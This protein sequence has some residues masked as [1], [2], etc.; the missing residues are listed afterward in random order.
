MGDISGLSS[1]EFTERDKEIMCRLQKLV[2]AACAVAG[3]AVATP[4]IAAP[5]S[6][7]S[8]EGVNW[9]SNSLQACGAP[10]CSG[11]AVEITPHTA[12]QPNNPDGSGAVWISYA[13]TGV[14]GKHAVNEANPLMSVTIDLASKAGWGVA[15]K[16]W[17]DDTA[18]VWFNGELVQPANVSQSTCAA[19]KIGCEPQEFGEFFW[20]AK[21]NDV[22]RID[23]YQVG[24]GTTA[25]ENPFGLLY[26]GAYGSGVGRSADVPEPASM[27]LLGLGLL[28]A[29]LARGRRKKNQ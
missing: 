14:D 18:A 16:V 1:G 6:F 23:A 28:G 17:A 12:W 15:L 26:Y 3:V 20:K 7:V 8:K 22:I 25:A 10:S 2:V 19:G 27:A 21:G 24:T 4:V 5:I 9:T 11:P 29:G 13:E